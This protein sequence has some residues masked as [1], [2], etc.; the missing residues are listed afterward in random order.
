MKSGTESMKIVTRF[1]STSGK[2][3]LKKT[4]NTDL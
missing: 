1:T 4:N 3:S 2:L